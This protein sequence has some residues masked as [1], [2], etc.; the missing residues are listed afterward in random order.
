M[1][2]KKRKQRQPRAARKIAGTGSIVTN[3]EPATRAEIRGASKHQLIRTPDGWSAVDPARSHLNQVI[4]GTGMDIDQDVQN[5]LETIAV[6]NAKNGSPDPF[7]TII[8]SA[9]PEYFRPDGQTPGD[10]DPKRLKDWEDKTIKWVKDTFGQDVVSLISNLDETTPHMH[11]AVVPTYLKKPR[12][13]DRKRAGES[14]EAFQIRVANALADPGK[15]TLSRSRNAVF[16][17]YNSFKLL[18]ESYA[19]AMAPLGLA[20]SLDSFDPK[21]QMDPRSTRD[22]IQDTLE[23]IELDESKLRRQEKEIA[24]ELAKWEQRN[25][26]KEADLQEQRRQLNEYQS[27]LRQQQKLLADREAHITER[28]HKIEAAIGNA[29]RT[30]ADIFL[31][32]VSGDI[33]RGPNNTHWTIPKDLKERHPRFEKIWT[34]IEPALGHFENLWSRLTTRLNGKDKE[35]L[36]AS[37]QSSLKRAAS[38]PP[39]DNSPSF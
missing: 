32:I 39:S 33:F 9:S 13:P 3:F 14:D 29:I 30:I 31:G 15:R 22:F 27:K 37:T 25:R 26:R 12:K 5:Y 19:K 35:N 1:A 10:E 8:L 23:K 2:R 36:E 4:I 21:A 28:E 34:A 7:V 6:S 11:L 18:R 16:G 24:E 20:Y 17:R 38:P